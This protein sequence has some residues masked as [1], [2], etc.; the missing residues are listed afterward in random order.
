MSQ[1][2]RVGCADQAKKRRSEEVRES[3]KTRRLRRPRPRRC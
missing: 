3:D 1:A 2:G